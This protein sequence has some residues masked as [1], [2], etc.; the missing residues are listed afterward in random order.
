MLPPMSGS[1]RV[2]FREGSPPDKSHIPKGSSITP[3]IVIAPIASNC[4]MQL[5]FSL[6]VPSF[7]PEPVSSVRYQ[8]AS[9]GE[10]NTRIPSCNSKCCA[11][12]VTNDRKSI[13]GKVITCADIG[14][15]LK[16]CWQKSFGSHGASRML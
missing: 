8:I 10:V 2:A 3:V 15:C 4:P 12:R 1:R 11:A 16:V 7:W 9:G 14:Q 5:S 13:F 6:H